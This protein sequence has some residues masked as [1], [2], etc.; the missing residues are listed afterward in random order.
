MN[1]HFSKSSEYLPTQYRLLLY[2]S[3]IKPLFSYCCT[4]WSNCGQTNLH[5]LVKLQKHCAR[6]I[7]DIPRNARSIDNFQKL[8]WLPI[9]Q[10]FRLSK[11]GHLKNVINRRV[12]DYLIKS[13]THFG[14][15]TSIP[16]DQKHYTTNRSRKLTQ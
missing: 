5:E 16:Q 14:S 12:S 11:L 3:S 10:M 13:W 15:S 6:L 7:L 4:V 1:C 9:D 2:N 8:K